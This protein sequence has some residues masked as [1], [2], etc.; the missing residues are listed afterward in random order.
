M[1]GVPHTVAGGALRLERLVFFSDAVFAIAITL[2]VLELKV[3][4]LE[5]DPAR[6]VPAMLQLIPQLFAFTLSFL[7]I[8]RF[9]MSHHQLMDHVRGFHPGLLW[10][11]L[12]LLMAIA[13][14]PFSTALIGENL[15]MFGPALFY[16]LTLLATA[17][18]D[19]RL[20]HKVEQLGIAD[21]PLTGEKQG[22]TAVVIGAA[23][24]TALT[25]V[26]PPI[27]QMGMAT[28]PL[29][30]WLLKRKTQR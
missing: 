1:S 7:V 17:L 18:C 26:F 10:P 25:F 6:F 29:W 12:L 8:G 27:S 23:L 20:V 28:I 3:P 14:M 24:S 4:H 15:G 19:L 5:R 16:N 22:G 30:I 11:N 13:F 2:L 21:G 9:W